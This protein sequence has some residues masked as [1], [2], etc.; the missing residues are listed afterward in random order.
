MKTPTLK[1]LF[2]AVLFLA[3]LSI[4]T[5]TAAT[6]YV[7]S[8]APVGGDGTSWATAYRSIQSAVTSASGLWM[9]C[10]S[11]NDSIYVKSG[12]YSLSSTITV[13]KVVNL[14]G[15][16]PNSMSDPSFSDRDP[17]VYQTIV[18]GNDTVRC[19][20]LTNKSKIDGFVI[21]HGDA[22][23]GAGV[24]VDAAPYDCTT[25]W[26]T[27]KIRNCVF[28][29]NTGGAIYDNRSDVEVSD[30]TFSSNS[31]TAGG[32]IYHS[33]S[34]PLIERC[35][36]N[37]NEATAP[38][39]LGGGAIAGFGGNS[40][41]GQ[42]TR[43]NNCLFYDNYAQSRGGA[44]A[45]HDVYPRIKNC[46]FAD[47]DTDAVMGN[48]GAYY[49]FNADAPRL[50]NCIFW[51]NTPDQLDLRDN[52]GQQ[53]RYCD[54]QGGFTGV[55]ASYIINDNPDFVAS[56]DYHLQ[57][58]SPCIDTGSNNYGITDDLEGRTRPLDGDDDGVATCDMGA[59]EYAY[60]DLIIE[61]IETNP[62][63]PAPGE[64]VDVD[65]TI[66]NQGTS[67]TGSFWLDWYADRASPPAISELGDEYEQVSSLAAGQTTVITLSYSG[68][69]SAGAYQMYA[70][71]DTEEQVDESEETN[72]IFGP[73]TINVNTCRA[74]INEDNDVNLLDLAR[75]GRAWMSTPG[76][77][78]WDRESDLTEPGDEIID[79]D[80]LEILS[81]DWLCSEPSVVQ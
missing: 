72:N 17:A 57:G 30:C 7:D 71:I 74:D 39:S 63:K 54:V 13:G 41:T 23:G 6:W 60:A 62:Y 19:F 45:Y 59:Y 21:E 55:G 50:W 52:T 69:S 15:G 18:T 20:E 58:V 53:V 64:S 35:I 8:D 9:T 36:F 75:F 33:Y 1:P 70:Q 34:S 61:A 47:N 46:T 42:V 40:T 10:M 48:G 12:T 29:N 76:S 44:I 78:A 26:V 24:Y 11:P 56:G 5:V 73:Q 43:I 16:F 37:N 81:N 31:D 65:I 28:R 77:G 14:Y 2:V 38:A 3:M 22:T 4:S 25:F 66:T 51:G 80:D 68:Y 27:A 67:D 49:A 32:A 79:I